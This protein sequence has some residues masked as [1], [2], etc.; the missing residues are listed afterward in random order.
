MAPKDDVPALPKTG[1]ATGTNVRRCVAMPNCV[2]KKHRAVGERCL[3]KDTCEAQT[4]KT[5]S[6]VADCVYNRGTN[7]CALKTNIPC[8]EYTKARECVHAMPEGATLGCR[9]NKDAEDK[10][11]HF[12]EEQ[13]CALKSKREG[14][15][16]LGCE[17]NASNQKCEIP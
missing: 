6:T 12:C 3:D 8:S 13:Q 17:W 14:C 16:Q 2:W 10:D 9:W 11:D 15:E 5:C 7:R 1:C 4:K